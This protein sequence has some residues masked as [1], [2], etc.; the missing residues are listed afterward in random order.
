MTEW[1]EWVVAEVV[2][3]VPQL[4]LLGLAFSFTTGA[5]VLVV[6]GCEYLYRRLSPGGRPD[7]LTAFFHR[8]VVALD[9]MVDEIEDLQ[10][11]RDQH[12]SPTSA[13]AAS[14]HDDDDAGTVTRRVG[15]DDAEFDLLQRDAD[16]EEQIMYVVHPLPPPLPRLALWATRR[17]T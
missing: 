17:T 3:E 10:R 11:L 15:E 1:V 16:I 13:A 7:P 8:D 6:M 4:A 12:R 14:R 9:Q 5:L 2:H